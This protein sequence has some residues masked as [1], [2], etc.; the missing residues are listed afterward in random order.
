MPLR[1]SGRNTPKLMANTPDQP[2]L[3]EFYY[4]GKKSLQ[5]P[6]QAISVAPMK[7]IL[8]R[9]L[10]VI[11]AIV[12]VSATGAGVYYVSSASEPSRPGSR[13]GCPGTAHEAAKPD[14]G[15]KSDCGAKPDCDAKPDCGSEPAC[16]D[17][18]KAEDQNPT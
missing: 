15:A 2:K 10:L 4:E 14:C 18:Q 11:T 9:A 3:T 13:G 16:T 7:A 17:Q 6:Q 8:D 12:A 1:Q 5:K